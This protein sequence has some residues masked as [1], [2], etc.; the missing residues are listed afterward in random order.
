MK[1]EKYGKRKQKQMIQK[2]DLTNF[3]GNQNDQMQLQMHYN[4]TKVLKKPIIN[5]QTKLEDNLLQTTLDKNTPLL[6]RCFVRLVRLKA[7][8]DKIGNTTEFEY[9][10]V[11]T[12]PDKMTPLLRKCSDRLA[13]LEE[14]C[15]KLRNTTDQ[16]QAQTQYEGTKSGKK[17]RKLKTTH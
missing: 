5:I 12:T 16:V 10:P 15:E 11:K 17:I 6:K 7:G 1:T 14:K 13:R 8:F 4:M 9:N 3:T 2:H